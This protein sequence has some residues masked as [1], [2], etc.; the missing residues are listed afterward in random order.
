MQSPILY[1]SSPDG[2][3]WHSRRLAY[4]LHFLVLV[5][6]TLNL[7]IA[8]L[9]IVVQEKKLYLSDKPVYKMGGNGQSAYYWKSLLPAIGSIVG[10]I[11]AYIAGGGIAL[12]VASY[13]KHQGLNRGLSLKKI[14]HLGQLGEWFYCSERTASNHSLT[15]DAD[16]H[17]RCGSAFGSQSPFRRWYHHCGRTELDK[18]C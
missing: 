6:L 3:P 8:A 2:Y 11:N 17:S 5:C 7:L 14:S 18:L 16:L 15:P 1:H 13:A 9:V 4:K 10:S 12:L